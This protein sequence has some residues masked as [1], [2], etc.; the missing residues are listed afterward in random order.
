MQDQNP[1]HQLLLSLNGAVALVLT[2]LV[3]YELYILRRK[4]RSRVF[5]S[6]LTLRLVRPDYEAVAT[7]KL[8]TA[9]IAV[10]LTMLVAIVAGQTGARLG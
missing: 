1:N 10:P 3:G 5:G 7:Y 6:K 8:A 4:L 2:G 9:F